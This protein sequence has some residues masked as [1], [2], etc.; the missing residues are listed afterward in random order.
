MKMHE[1]TVTNLT[2]GLTYTIS[3][4]VKSSDTS[5]EKSNKRCR[6]KTITNQC[7]TKCDSIQGPFDTHKVT[8]GTIIDGNP[9]LDVK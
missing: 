2:I 7:T 9:F 8:Q 1:Y 6:L 4:D 5:C 3:L